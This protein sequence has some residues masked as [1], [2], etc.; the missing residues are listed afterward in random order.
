M[1]LVRDRLPEYSTAAVRICAMVGR[2]PNDVGYRG[3]TR[4]EPFAQVLELGSA[5]T[6]N[7][8]TSVLKDNLLCI[9]CFP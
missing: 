7:T 3:P 6:A 8:I 1:F 5:E 2:D 4:G 9:E